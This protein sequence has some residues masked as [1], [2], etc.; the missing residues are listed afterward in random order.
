MDLQPHFCSFQDHLC[1]LKWGLYDEWR[2]WPFWEGAIV[3]APKF[4]KS[5]LPLTPAV[6]ILQEDCTAA[7]VLCC[8]PSPHFFQSHIATDDQSISKSWCRAPSGAHSPTFV[9][10]WQLRF[11]FSGAPSLTRGGVCLWYQLLVLASVVS[12]GS[13]SLGTRDYILLSQ[14]WDFSFRR[15]LRLAGSRWRYSTPSPHGC[16]STAEANLF[17]R[18]ARPI[19]SHLRSD[20]IRAWTLLKTLFAKVPLLLLVYPLLS[21]TRLLW[22]HCSFFQGRYSRMTLYKLIFRWLDTQYEKIR[23]DI[24]PLGRNESLVL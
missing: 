15:L 17:H 9:T 1:V 4:S 21:N 8:W 11:C 14:I 23:H 3:V 7:A 2:G 19:Y 5:L 13:E 18:N 16:I 12:L 10:F 6:L 24:T 20:Q 22:L